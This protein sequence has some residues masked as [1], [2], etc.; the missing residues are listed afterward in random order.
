MRYED[1]VD[2]FGESVKNERKKINMLEIP[3]DGLGC[4]SP[5]FPAFSCDVM[6][7]SSTIVPIITKYVKMDDKEIRGFIYKKKYD[8]NGYLIGYEDSNDIYK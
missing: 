4:W 6:L 3:Q 5:A 1:Y 7:A 8:K 2:F